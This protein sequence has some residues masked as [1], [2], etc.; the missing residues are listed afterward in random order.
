MPLDGQ[1]PDVAEGQQQQVEPIEPQ[2]EPVGAPVDP[3]LVP[4]AKDVQGA[5]KAITDAWGKQDSSRVSTTRPR[6]WQDSRAKPIVEFVWPNVV[7]D[8]G[9]NRPFT[10]SPIYTASWLVKDV[11]GVTTSVVWRDSMNPPYN[12]IKIEM[13]S[14]HAFFTGTDLPDF[15]YCRIRI[16]DGSPVDPG[17]VLACGYMDGYTQ[18]TTAGPNGA[19]EQSETWT[20]IGFYDL[21]G[22]AE[23]YGDLGLRTGSG[24]GTLIPWIEYES[25]LNGVEV[26]TEDT[27]MLGP[28]LEFMWRAAYRDKRASV[29]VLQSSTKGR[30]QVDYNIQGVARLLWPVM[31]LQP[32]SKQGM[33]GMSNLVKVVH[34]HRAPPAGSGGTPALFHAGLNCPFVPGMTGGAALKTMQAG[35]SLSSL[36]AGTFLCDRTMVE[37]FPTILYNNAGDTKNVLALIYRMK[38]FRLTKG[39]DWIKLSQKTAAYAAK[40]RELAQRHGRKVG[41]S[42]T[43]YIDVLHDASSKDKG[44]AAWKVAG[45]KSKYLRDLLNRVRRSYQ[46]ATDA[47]FGADS[48]PKARSM[49]VDCP[50]DLVFSFQL[51]YSDTEQVNVVCGGQYNTPDHYNMFSNFAGVPIMGRDK[52]WIQGARVFRPTWPHQIADARL[53]GNSAQRTLLNAAMTVRALAVEAAQTVLDR[54][55]FASGSCTCVWNPDIR[56][57]RVVRFRGLVGDYNVAS[58][59]VYGTT[60]DGLGGGEAANVDKT[61]GSITYAYI[62]DVTHTYDLDA[63]SGAVKLRTA[64]T[65]SHHV[66]HESQRMNLMHHEVKV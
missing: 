57:G 50:R 16:P 36:L 29:K 5:R 13:R 45:N 35:G 28:G 4:F 6:L 14:S 33:A 51:R 34:D 8:S 2:V 26:V 22:R 21:C 17:R 32:G 7:V 12:T 49:A 27:K 52:V 58:E 18:S 20:F 60:P 31:L 43:V 19:L 47:A 24:R 65:F 37:L 1:E 11:G 48:W 30:T 10:A 3:E 55:F 15:L 40:A 63:A 25:L 42:S 59:I 61:V 9:E 39:G 66:A 62:E 54:G 56:P 38:P 64:F 53:K 44:I 23:V 46:R 41:K